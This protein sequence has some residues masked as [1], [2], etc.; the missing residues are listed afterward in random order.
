MTR[1]VVTGA[2]RGIG[3]EFVRQLADRGDSVAAI[4]RESSTELNDL[5]VDVYE[6]V[7]VADEDSVADL[8]RRLEG[9]PIDL[10]INNA[11]FSALR[12]SRI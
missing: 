5:A 9:D 12:R 3:L 7:D 11:G 10:L 2:N 8:A 4:C 6:G 1:S